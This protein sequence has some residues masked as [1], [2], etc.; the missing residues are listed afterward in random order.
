MNTSVCL[1]NNA[2][3]V[4]WCVLISIYTCIPVYAYRTTQS[5]RF[6]QCMYLPVSYLP[7]R[8]RP[9][10]E[11]THI[12]PVV[13][14]NPPE[15]NYTPV[16]FD[17]KYNDFRPQV[18]GGSATDLPTE[19]IPHAFLRPVHHSSTAS[20]SSAGNGTPAPYA[21]MPIYPHPYGVRLPPVGMMPVKDI[22]VSHHQLANHRRTKSGDSIGMGNL[23]VTPSHSRQP[24]DVT[25]PAESRRLNEYV[26][27]PYPY[28]H[29]YYPPHYYHSSG[30]ASPSSH[31]MMVSERELERRH[32]AGSGYSTPY[33]PQRPHTADLLEAE[34]PRG[35]SPMLYHKPQ[36][37][38]V[39][40]PP[41]NGDQPVIHPFP[42]RGLKVQ[43]GY[44]STSHLPSKP[45]EGDHTMERF[46]TAQLQG[47]QQGLSDQ[48]RDSN[49][50]ETP[51]S[52]SKSESKTN[53][54]N[55]SLSNKLPGSSTNI[56]SEVL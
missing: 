7:R 32:L 5:A 20:L 53:V 44:F 4:Y 54:S 12:T 52:D 33:L 8:N 43:P 17:G 23:G 19:F 40:Q 35:Q 36:E 6:A 18:V 37:S 42:R 26:Y 56:E 25:V 15:N 29:H 46:L 39:S 3:A 45:I 2:C 11:G 16:D 13:I 28:Y 21:M 51:S 27:Y 9:Q 10:E 14:A 50:E 1:P 47:S 22:P 55:L 34:V 31:R 49:H 30:Y 41:M 24:S 48:H 38:V